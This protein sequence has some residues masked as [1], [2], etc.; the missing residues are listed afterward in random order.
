[1]HFPLRFLFSGHTPIY[2]WN[3]KNNQEH[4]DTYI[5]LILEYEHAEQNMEDKA[6]YYSDFLVFEA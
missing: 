1:L 2:L 6:F 4:A 3:T 5:D